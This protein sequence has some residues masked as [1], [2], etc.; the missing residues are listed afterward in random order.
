MRRIPYVIFNAN[1]LVR[2][3]IIGFILSLFVA[4]ISVLVLDVRTQMSN[5]AT[6]SS[7]NVQFAMTQAETEVQ[8]LRIAAL[9]NALSDEADLTEVRLRYDVFYSRVQTLASSAVFSDLRSNPR[10]AEQLA[11]LQDFLETWTPVIDGDDAQLLSALPALAEDAVD[12][13]QAARRISLEGIE[14]FSSIRD[15]QRASVARTLFNIAVLTVALVALLLIVAVALMRVARARERDLADNRLIRKRMETIISTSLDAVIVTNRQG[16][17]EDY[18]GAAERIFG[19][20]REEAIGADMAELVIPD[21]FRQ[22]HEAGMRRYLDTGQFRVIDQ[23]IVQLEAKRKG[24]DVFPV[25]FSLARANSPTGEIFIGFVRDISDRVRVERTLKAAR[26]RA[27]EGE[28]KKAELLAVMSHEMRTPLNGILGSLQLLDMDS[29]DAQTQR[30]L[31]IIQSSGKLLLGHVN[32]VLDISRLDAGKMS[33]QK[34]RFDLVDLLREIV[35]SQ[36]IQAEQNGN[37]LLLT[38]PSPSLHEVY[39]DPD[40][41]RQILLN[42]ISNAIKFTQN[43]TITLEAECHKG[44]REVEL[45]VIDTGVGIAEEDLERIFGDFVTIDSTYSRKAGGTGLGLGISQRLATALGGELGAESELGDGSLFWLRLPMDAPENAAQVLPETP[46]EDGEQVVPAG[47]SMNVLVVED[48]AINRMV[49]RKML[50]TGG[51]TVTEAHDGGQGVET[52]A[53]VAFDVI[54]MDISMPVMDGVAA[55]KEIRRSGTNVPIIATTAHAMPDELAAF[56][57]AG[58]NDVLIKPISRAA[59]LN[60]LARISPSGDAPTKA[61]KTGLTIFDAAHFADIATEF[62]D[63]QLADMVATVTTEVTAFLAMPLSPDKDAR[64]ALAAEAHRMAGS[65]GVF[66][67][68]RLAALLREFQSAA[69]TAAMDDLVQMRRKIAACWVQ[70]S[71]ALTRH[72]ATS[73]A[74]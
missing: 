35:E 7:D 8:M 27:V 63:S 68:M 48:N 21:H 44:L 66:G 29:Y 56:R 2:R 26:D 25:D 20:S 72:L 33:M 45:R 13:R 9:K 28:R 52:A 14:F 71:R 15:M 37:K 59:L 57:A 46:E 1:S 38:P 12:A 6:A 58:M 34:T 62:S 41:L 61:A 22:G 4:T 40:R 5:L 39:S 19:Y 32:D 31:R 53:Q 18:N 60:M 74:S 67:A 55:T 64:Q 49:V 43:G 70:T 54:L 3:G 30:Y 10:T 51:H 36:S 17:I 24:G 11:F 73:D 50:E 16:R 69:P 23:G 65:T 47:K 42:L